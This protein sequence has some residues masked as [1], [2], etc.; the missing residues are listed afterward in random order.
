M[1]GK[2]AAAAAASA[3]LVLLAAGCGAGGTSSSGT[4]ETITIGIPGPAATLLPVLLGADQGLFKKEGVNVQVK[5]IAPQQ[6][7]TALAGGSIQFAALPSPASDIAALDGAPVKWYGSWEQHAN[8]VI[9]TRPEITSLGKL[10]GQKVAESA[11][12]T[13]QA[14]LFDT[15]LAQ[16]GVKPDSV[17]RQIVSVPTAPVPLFVQ[18]QIKAFVSTEP[19]TSQVLA[20][21]PGAHKAFNLATFDW[22]AAGLAGNSDW[23][24][25]HQ[26][27]AVK[28]ISAI[29]AS[30]ALWRSDPAAAKAVIAK[31]SSISRGNVINAAYGASVDPQAGMSSRVEPVSQQ[32]EQFVLSAMKTHGFPK[33]DP[34]NW[35]TF[36][37]STLVAKAGA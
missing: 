9:L 7:I 19:T 2:L 15:A 5:V 10:E 8:A 23:V 3:A 21:V 17:Q 1:L 27:Q 11:P 28:V 12:G 31:A 36:V 35:A 14:M 13:L 32:T 34:A 37:G 26:D 18:G 6:L 16:S 20:L 29:D 24:S 30:L 33:A 22:T 4:G 25:A